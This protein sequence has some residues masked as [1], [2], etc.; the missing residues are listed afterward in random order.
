MKTNSNEVSKLSNIGI[1]DRLDEVRMLIDFGSLE[2]QRML[3]D[4]SVTDEGRYLTDRSYA[5]FYLVSTRAMDLLDELK[6][7][8][9]NEVKHNLDK[10]EE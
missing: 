4:I 6:Q 5:A 7:S 8:L 10:G 1:I 2:I 3:D 9:R